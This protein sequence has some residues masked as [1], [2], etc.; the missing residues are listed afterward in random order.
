MTSDNNQPFGVGQG[1]I[2]VLVLILSSAIMGGFLWVILKLL[3][4][5]NPNIATAIL[6]ASVTIL[7]SV[8]SLIYSKR[9]ERRLEIEQELRKQKVPLYENF[10]AFWFRI[11]QAQKP[12]LEPI[13]D[14]E[15]ANFIFEFSHKLIIWGSDDVLKQYAEFRN[16][17][18]D[19][20]GATPPKSFELMLSFEKLLF[21]LRRDMGHKNKNLKTG[22]ILSLFINDT[23]K[24]IKV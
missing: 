7:V 21:A 15:M 6:A 23:K 5:L 17:S 10:M 14:K 22:Y 18:F 2:V 20:I 1:I 4:T 11:L 12:G 9:W 13:T 3:G 24:Y 16:T 8:V 19:L